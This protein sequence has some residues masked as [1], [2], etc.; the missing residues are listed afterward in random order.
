MTWH[1]LPGAGFRTLREGQRCSFA[2][3]QD[4]HGPVATEVHLLG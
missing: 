1:A 4:Q 2:R 3:D